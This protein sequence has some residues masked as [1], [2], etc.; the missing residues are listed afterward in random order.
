M[1]TTVIYKDLNH[2]ARRG[3]SG[4]TMQRRPTPSLERQA[5]QDQPQLDYP[6]I[7]GFLAE[8]KSI[9][10]AGLVL[11]VAFCVGCPKTSDSD[12][13][14]TGDTE[15]QI[16]GDIVDTSSHYEEHALALPSVGSHTLYS[17]DPYGHVAYHVDLVVLESALAAWIAADEESLLVLFDKLLSAHGLYELA[18]KADL[19]AIQVELQQA[20]AAAWW[21]HEGR[22]GEPELDDFASIELVI[23][24]WVKDEPIDGDIG[25]AR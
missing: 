6:T 3:Y 17:S 10:R 23:D 24:E 22:A 13:R 14:H 11:G 15:G 7:R 21:T 8:G 2:R 25:K 1:K 9:T 5:R 19:S 4:D 20:L 12:T 18:P 16:A